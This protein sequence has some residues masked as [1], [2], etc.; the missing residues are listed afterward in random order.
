MASGLQGS[1]TE[2][3][4]NWG[5]SLVLLVSA[6]ASTIYMLL[7]HRRER[8]A[9]PARARLGE[10]LGKVSAVQW[11]PEEARSSIDA[12][13][14]SIIDMF[15]NEIARQHRVRVERKRLAAT[16]KWAGFAL[17]TVGLICPLVVMLAPDL[18][19]LEKVNYTIFVVAS[20]CLASS[21]I[22][23]RPA[24]DQRL[25][26]KQYGLERLLNKF[27]LD[28][29]EWRRATSGEADWGGGFDILRKLSSD[30]YD[31]LQERR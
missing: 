3:L 6:I 7:L 19:Q 27:V 28:W 15:H 24:E 10:F 23:C 14:S 4:T 5:L 18:R 25:L 21:E 20:A 8:Q 30:V 9:G 2:T 29:S 31:V 16:F 12:L 11:S 22:L 17:I 13:G 1:M 26:L